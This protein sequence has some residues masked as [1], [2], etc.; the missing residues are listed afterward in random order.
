MR[1]QDHQAFHDQYI[2]RIEG[3]N[4]VVKEYVPGNTLFFESAVDYTKQPFAS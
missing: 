1:A 2:A 3:D 4:L